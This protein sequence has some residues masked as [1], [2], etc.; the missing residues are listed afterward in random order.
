MVGLY[1]GLLLKKYSSDEGMRVN[2]QVSKKK[3]KQGDDVE[4]SSP[5]RYEDHLSISALM[6]IKSNRGEN[7]RLF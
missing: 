6:L 4:G 7:S 2:T 3:Y 1:C 5:E